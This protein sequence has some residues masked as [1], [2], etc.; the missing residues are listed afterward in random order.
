[1]CLFY[2]LLISK[3]YVHFFQSCFTNNTQPC[4]SL[5]GLMLGV[6]RS[7]CCTCGRRLLLWGPWSSR[8]STWMCSPSVIL[9]CPSSGSLL[10]NRRC[11]LENSATQ[12]RRNPPRG[13]ETE[14]SECIQTAYSLPTKLCCNFFSKAQVKHI[15]AKL[16]LMFWLCLISTYLL[17]FDQVHFICKTKQKV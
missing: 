13:A 14:R 1:M 17:Y 4:V 2:T 12:W 7:C 10:D 8:W 11:D 16:T 3:N 15:R 5:Y 9:N 6:R